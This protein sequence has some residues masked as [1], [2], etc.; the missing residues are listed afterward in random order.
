MD[1]PATASMSTRVPGI[2]PTRWAEAGAGARPAEGGSA[3]PPAAGRCRDPSGA[4]TDIARFWTLLDRARDHRLCPLMLLA[5][6]SGL[7]RG[8]LAGLR[9]SDIDLA[10]A[11][12]VVR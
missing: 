2:V 7:R 4:R 9:R 8:A 3:P 1:S 5:G 11:Q 12:L 10:T 6:N